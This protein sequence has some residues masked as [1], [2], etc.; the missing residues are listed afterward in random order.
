MRQRNWYHP[1]M[2]PTK[3]G[4]AIKVFLEMDDTTLHP[5]EVTRPQYKSRIRKDSSP[6]TVKQNNLALY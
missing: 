3:Y 6:I 1:D 2:G 4:V 5:Q